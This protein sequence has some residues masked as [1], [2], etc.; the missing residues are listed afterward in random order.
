M[1]INLDALRMGYFILYR[2]DGGLFGNLIEK[3]QKKKGSTPEDAKYTHIEVSGGGQWSVNVS[4][5]KAKVV[6]IT[7][8]HKGRHI[9]VVR[10]KNDTYDKKGR[11]KVAFWA[12]SN[13]NLGYDWF[14]ILRFKLKFMF[15]QKRMF[16]CSENALWALQKEFIGALGMKPEKC[17]PSRFLRDEFE[18]VWEGEI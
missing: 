15:H 2:N 14:G 3:Q 6:D 1:S 18:L 10:F 8:V 17:M 12:A 16:F 7:K 5:P 11:Y 4:P 13:C 9:K